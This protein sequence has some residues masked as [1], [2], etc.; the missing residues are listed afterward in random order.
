VDICTLKFGGKKH[1][2]LLKFWVTFWI[3]RVYF[4]KIWVIVTQ[5]FEIWVSTTQFFRE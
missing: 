1:S 3:S 4:L 2:S 5:I